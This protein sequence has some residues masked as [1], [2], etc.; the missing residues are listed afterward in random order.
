MRLLFSSI[1]FSSI[2][3]ASFSRAWTQSSET[4]A[5]CARSVLGRK[6]VSPASHDVLIR[7]PLGHIRVEPDQDVQVVI[8]DRE[9]RNGRGEDLSKFLKPMLDPAI[10]VEGP[11]PEQEGAAHTARHAVI[12]ASHRSINQMRTRDRHGRPG[13][14]HTI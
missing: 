13:I 14:T 2:H 3:F 8:Q 4:E 1:H 6:E 11:F 10:T 7:P 5:T 9:P 12:P